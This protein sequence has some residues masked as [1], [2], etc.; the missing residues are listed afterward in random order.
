M[1]PAAAI[2]S[3]GMFSKSINLA[4]A[5][6]LVFLR[7]VEELLNCMNLHGWAT[8]PESMP[9][10]DSLRLRNECELS[11]Q[12]GNFR[13]AGVGRGETLEV[14]SEI[15]L[16]EV[17]WLQP[18]TESTEQQIYLSMLET[19]RLAIN[20]RFFLGLFDYEGHFAVYPE[21]AFYKPHLDC[22]AGTS[23]R[24]VTTILYLNENWQP[25]DGG[26]LKLWITPEGRDGA[27]VLI[28]PRMG[29][30]VCFLA[31]DFWHEVLPAR[32]TRMSITGWF[33]QRQG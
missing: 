14:R 27:F 18:D 16:D 33:R 19:L 23:D 25:G 30:L 22:H 32:K 11:W 28:E 24:I 2:C 4:H 20:Q 3:G 29:T 31:A 17:M 15:R 7:Q 5:A 8:T 1:F 9:P 21:G 13:R 26:E 6:G 10:A 12:S